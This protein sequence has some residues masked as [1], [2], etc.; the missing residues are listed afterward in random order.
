M[1]EDCE[2]L[3][4]CGSLLSDQSGV[5]EWCREHVA[6]NW[7]EKKQGNIAYVCTLA[8][9]YKL[10]ELEDYKGPWMGLVM[11]WVFFPLKKTQLS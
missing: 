7:R 10:R 3:E 9:V 6:L 4:I 2:V 11:Y 5:V 1:D 8:D